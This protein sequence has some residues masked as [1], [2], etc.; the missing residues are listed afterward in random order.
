MRLACRASGAPGYAQQAEG[1]AESVSHCRAGLDHHLADCG[2]P[3]CCTVP[4]CLPA[5]LC[6][7]STRRPQ[8]LTPSVGNYPI[9]P[10]FT[11]IRAVSTALCST[12]VH[13]TL[14]SCGAFSSCRL[15]SSRNFWVLCE[16]C[17]QRGLPALSLATPLTAAMSTLNSSVSLLNF[18]QLHCEHSIESF[19]LILF[20]YSAQ[21]AGSWLPL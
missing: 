17:M 11:A 15:Q 6:T 2:L 19:V 12:A 9:A 7:P 4:M 13:R 1:R 16:A 10:R 8:A 21:A 18:A 14:A 3:C 5:W 20:L